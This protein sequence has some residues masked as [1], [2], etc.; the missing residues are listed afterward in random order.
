MR[1]SI[2]DQIC[3]VL[4]LFIS[5]NELREILVVHSSLFFQRHNDFELPLELLKR[6]EHSLLV[7]H[8]GIDLLS[9]LF[10][11]EILIIL[12]IKVMLR[13]NLTSGTFNVARYVCNNSTG[14][15]LKSLPRA[16]D[17]SPTGLTNVCISMPETMYGRLQHSFRNKLRKYRRSSIVSPF[18]LSD[19]LGGIGGIKSP[20]K[21][22]VRHLWKS[23]KLEKRLW[24]SMAPSESRPLIGYS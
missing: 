15:V 4:R 1:E 8:E 7:L 2:W 10:D 3:F 22:S 16:F 24:I 6:F 21:R 17:S 9:E 18:F 14:R 13:P 19:A 23:T 11:L 12:Q 20:G 5:L